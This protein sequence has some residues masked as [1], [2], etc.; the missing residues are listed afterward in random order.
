VAAPMIPK[1]MVTAEQV[2]SAIDQD[3]RIISVQEAARS[4]PSRR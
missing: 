1:T 2:M 3:S 4:W